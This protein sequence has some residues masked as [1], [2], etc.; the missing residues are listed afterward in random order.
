MVFN[1]SIQRRVHQVLTSLNHLP[2]TSVGVYENGNSIW[3]TDVKK[4]VPDFH[5]F[6]CDIKQHYR[7][8]IYVGSK[9]SATE[10]M[11]SQE[12]SKEQAGYAICNIKSSLV[13]TGFAALYQFLHKNR[14]NNKK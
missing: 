5:L 6:W 8:Y 9:A 13:A 4:F 11:E 10:A 7:V 2:G 1:N 14:S 12:Y 3:I